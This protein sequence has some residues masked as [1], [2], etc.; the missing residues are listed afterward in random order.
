M[1]LSTKILLMTILGSL[2][3]LVAAGLMAWIIWKGDKYE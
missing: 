3:W 2:G 1:D